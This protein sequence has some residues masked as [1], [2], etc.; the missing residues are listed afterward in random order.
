MLSPPQRSAILKIGI[1]PLPFS[2]DVDNGPPPGGVAG[3]GHAAGHRGG[4]SGDHLFEGFSPGLVLQ[5][6]PTQR[7]ESFLYKVGL[8]D[9][10]NDD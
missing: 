10:D 9:D 6:L 8:M 4:A 5:N 1:F 7:R 2:F 3:G